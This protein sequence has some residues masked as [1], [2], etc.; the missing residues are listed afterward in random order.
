MCIR[1]RSFTVNLSF[2]ITSALAMRAVK[3][4]VADAA[5]TMLSERRIGA[6]RSF[7]VRGPPFRLVEAEPNPAGLGTY[8]GRTIGTLAID[9]GRRKGE[10]V[11]QSRL[12]TGV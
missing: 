4:S 5:A 9:W 7:M 2:P 12:N 10:E 1:D 8:S 6:C 3:M 11:L